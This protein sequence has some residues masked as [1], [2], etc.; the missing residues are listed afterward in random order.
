MQ[1]ALAFQPQV[2]QR[3]A[4]GLQH[5]GGADARGEDVGV[6]VEVTV[7]LRLVQKRHQLSTGAAHSPTTAAAAVSGTTARCRFEWRANGPVRRKV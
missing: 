5:D 2:R 4:G 3:V 1:L 6:R 7:G